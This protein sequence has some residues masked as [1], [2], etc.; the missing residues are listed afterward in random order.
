MCIW[1]LIDELSAVNAMSTSAPV[2]MFTPDPASV[3]NTPLAY[4]IFIALPVLIAVLVVVGRVLT[5]KASPP[6]DG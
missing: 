6:H 2:A 5:S 4:Y 1:Q 3:T